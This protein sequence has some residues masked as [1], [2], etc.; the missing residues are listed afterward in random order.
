MC[1]RCVFF[2]GGIGGWVT[3]AKQQVCAHIHKQQQGDSIKHG[4]IFKA[5]P[6]VCGYVCRQAVCADMMKCSC[7]W[8]CPPPVG[9]HLCS[10]HDLPGDPGLLRG[11]HTRW[12]QVEPRKQE[13]ARG[14]GAGSSGAGAHSTHTGETP[15]R[16]RKGCVL[17]VSPE[18]R[19]GTAQRSRWSGSGSSWLGWRSALYMLGVVDD[20]CCCAWLLCRWAAHCLVACTCVACLGGRGGGCLLQQA[21]WA[22][23][24]CCSWMNQP[25]V[26]SC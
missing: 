2:G 23:P 20:A 1:P 15:W 22:R 25:Q 5:Y 16:G 8:L 24:Q 13:G 21:S 6:F 14:G 4:N 26:K 10:H 3:Q 9:G 17:T 11:C 19:S 18:S 7:V 12:G